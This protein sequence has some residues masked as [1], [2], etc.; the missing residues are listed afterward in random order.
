MTD[1]ERIRQAL[2]ERNLTIS[3]LAQAGQVT[4]QAAQKWTKADPIGKQARRTACAALQKLGIDPGALFPA[5]A[6]TPILDDLGASEL[7]HGDALLR[8]LE[9]SHY[10]QADLAR[11]AG[12]TRAGVGVWCDAERFSPA[13]W[14]GIVA[15]L[16]Q[17]GLAPEGVFK[18]VPAAR[19]LTSQLEGWSPAQLEALAR[20]LKAAAKDAH[21]RDVLLAYLDGALRPR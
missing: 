15:G 7:H 4:W 3:H 18:P 1:G 19:H 8:Y 20:I 21:T 2:A 6:M 11:A 13:V 14:R 5:E 10:S 9:K 16:L 12:I 17:L